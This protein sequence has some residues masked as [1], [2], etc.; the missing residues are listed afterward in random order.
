MSGIISGVIDFNNKGISKEIKNSMIETIKSSGCEASFFQKWIGYQTKY[1]NGVQKIRE[2]NAYVSIL[3]SLIKGF[4]D[5]VILLLGVY[6]ILMGRFTAGTL[7]AF[8]SFLSQFLSPVSDLVGIGQEIQALSGDTAK[9]ED[10]LRYQPDVKIDLNET[11]DPA[12]NKKD[13]KKLNGKVEIKD[14]TFSYSP[15]SAPVLKDLNIKAEKGQMIALVGGS[16]SGKSTISK[17]IAGLYPVEHGEIL[18]DGK[19]ISEIDRLVYRGSLSMVDQEVTLFQDTIRN[20]ITMWDTSIDE[21]TLIKAC[22][23]ACIHDDILLREN[24]YNHVLV[25]NGKDFSGGQRQRFEIAR[26]FVANP[27]IMILDEATS[28]LDP[29][30][31]KAV[32]DAVRRRGITCFIVAHRLSTIRD[33]DEIVMLEHGEIVERGTHK[34]LI[35]LDGKYA[36]LVKSE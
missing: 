25:E 28:A 29:T 34:E 7:L 19:K 9:I 3:P 22:K 14:V 21:E 30:T 35:E 10:V 26:A 20:N 24:G 31:E 1:S 36:R 23:D 18:F 33:A 13:F 5:I 8:Q 11:N 2:R 6:N 15:L 17:L 32:M 16:G 4:A 12:F 27:S